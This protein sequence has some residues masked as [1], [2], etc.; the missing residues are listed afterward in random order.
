VR[1]AKGSTRPLVLTAALCACLCG[2]VVAG[3]QAASKPIAAFT[4][5]GAYSFVSAP[6]L[7]PPKLSA[8]GKPDFRHLAGG[9]FFL[10]NF[11]NLAAKRR[12]VGQSG[13]MI[14]DSHLQPVWFA[15]IPTNLLA[16]NLKLQ[17]YAG[18][19]ALSWWQG[20]VNTS[21]AS[22]Q[23][24][25]ELVDQQYRPVAKVSA[26]AGSGWVLSLHDA[27]VSGNDMWVTAYRNVPGQN[28][29]PYGGSASGIVYDS[30]VQEYELDAV[31]GSS[32]KTGRLINSWDAYNPG[33]TPHIP[34]GDSYQRPFSVKAP[35][36]AYHVNSI[37]LIGAHQFLVSMRNTSA[38]YLVDIASGKIVWTLGGKHSTF[39]GSP[40]FHFQHD[41]ELHRGNVVSVFDDS[42]CA[43]TG[44]DKFAKPFGPSR[45]LV[46]RLDVKRRTVKRVAQY[47]HGKLIAAF[48]GN[49][50]LL[51]N[52]NV[53]IGW[54]S[55]PL[56]S[57]FSK[58][59]KLLLDV[60]WPTPD[61]SYRAYVQ[62][63]RATPYF[64]PSGA[65]RKHGS[66]VTVYASWNGATDV[67]SWRVLG[68]NDTKHLGRVGAGRKS[69]FETAISLK[70]SYKVYEVQALDGKGHVL[71]TS[72]S[73][74]TSK[75]ASGFY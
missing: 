38:A 27:V 31:P 43:L 54:G 44:P 21:G 50:Q 74:P 3:A 16:A 13:P 39:K 63:W 52:G 10:A 65:V 58:R 30:A 41:V 69:G 37:Q 17:S 9:D 24:E 2:A 7:H 53:A 47:K 5:R 20:V 25:V 71:G 33:G 60:Q 42:C 28:L 1:Q 23:G 12:M 32:V 26:P 61:Q 48:L 73:F 57:E 75:P 8:S 22:T 72:T 19:P 11:K 4:T 70:K 64:P 36:D 62:K 56:F 6:S 67:A 49:T 45:G 55:Q 35:W 68:G 34:L 59:G 46:L 18:K 40:P 51:G 15:P 29:K 14:L 66:S